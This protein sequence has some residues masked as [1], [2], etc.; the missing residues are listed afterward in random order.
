MVVYLHR[1]VNV[2][3]QQMVIKSVPPRHLIT[4]NQVCAFYH[5]QYG[6]A[7]KATAVI[8]LFSY[9]RFPL[10]NHSAPTKKACQIPSLTGR[11]AQKIN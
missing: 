8:N 6:A 1:F 3:N 5:K 7:T 11:F 2:N 9:G 4:F 10:N